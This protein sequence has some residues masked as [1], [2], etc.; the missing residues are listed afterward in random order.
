MSSGFFPFLIFHQITRILKL[1]ALEQTQT[2]IHTILN[3]SH[4][5]C[6]VF[7]EA[8]SKIITLAQIEKLFAN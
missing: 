3:R 4:Y 7:D 6:F 1:K 8:F 2:Y 5:G